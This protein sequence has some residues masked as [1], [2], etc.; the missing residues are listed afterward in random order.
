MVD[1]RSKALTLKWL[2]ENSEFV[3]P[4]VYI[5]EAKDWQKSQNDVISDLRKCLSGQLVV[6][7][8]S[9]SCE[10]TISGSAAGAFLSVIGVDM[11]EHD[12]VVNAVDSVFG[13]YDIDEF[14][15]AN[16]H[17]FVQPMVSDIVMSGVIF[18]RS[19]SDGSPYYVINYDDESGRTD[20]ITS[21]TGVSKTVSVYRGAQQGDFDSPRILRLFEFAK[22]IEATCKNGS[23]DIE[24]GIDADDVIHLF[25][26]RP[27]CGT[28]LWNSDLDAKVSEN[29]DHVSSFLKARFVQTDRLYGDRTILGVMPDWNP[30]EMIGVTPHPLACSLYRELITRRVW[31]K[32]R[33][34]MGYRKMPPEELMVIIAGRPYIDVRLSFNSFLP[35]NLDEEIADQLVSAWLQR[36]DS[37]PELHDKIEFDVAQTAMDFCFDKHLKERYPEV[38]SSGQ[39]AVFRSVLAAFTQSCIEPGGSGGMDYAE[40]L[41]HALEARHQ[42]RVFPEQHYLHHIADCVEECQVMGTLPFSILARHAFIAESLL[43][44]AVIRG[45]LLPERLAQ[46]KNSID[47]ISSEMSRD[48]IDV[49]KGKTDRNSFMARYGHLRPGSYDILSPQYRDR[50]ELFSSSVSV[51]QS[52]AKGEHFVF[53]TQEK[54]NLAKLLLEAGLSRL[55]PDLILQ[56]SIR[57]IKGRE[58]AKF[59]FTRNVSYILEMLA[60]WGRKYDFSREELAFLQISDVLAWNAVSLLRTGKDYFQEQIQ[61]GKSLYAVGRGIQLSYLIRSPRDVVIV[62]Q[63]RSAPNFIGTGAVTAEIVELDAHASCDISIEEKLYALR[64]QTLVLIG[65]LPVILPDL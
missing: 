21:G 65:F 7:R 60:R 30:A 3:I 57:A 61:S 9:C 2:A 17:C 35:I 14:F 18:T 28:E 4:P 27:I 46:L 13:S 5:I 20:T 42:N 16:E 40:N 29:L 49:F 6:V 62:P 58:Y 53:T 64:M 24:F 25:Q 11:D 41:I 12:G 54:N 43:R 52:H 45:A 36:L 31:S 48:F 50:E 47:T 51:P 33:E 63:H 26:V 37:K 1:F 19:N 15:M 56:Y 55:T 8:S 44:T 38:L 10:D 39:T 32:A 59:V 22:E 34:K 23:L